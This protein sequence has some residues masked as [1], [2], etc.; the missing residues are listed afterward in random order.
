MKTKTR[1]F[2]TDLVAEVGCLPHLAARVVSLAADPECNMAALARLILSDNVLTMRFLAL[3][4][5]AAFSRGQ[6]T[7]DLQGALVK[8]GLRRV[9]NVALMNGMGRAE[10]QKMLEA[11]FKDATP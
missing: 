6:E 9:R 11:C 4:N 1:Y 2:V 8:L 7:R 3:A 5:S 10:L